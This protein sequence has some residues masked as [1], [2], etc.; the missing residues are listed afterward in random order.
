MLDLLDQVEDVIS[1]EEPVRKDPKAFLS[2]TQGR[3][4]DERSIKCDS[5]VT[6]LAT[7]STEN[8]NREPP[9][10]YFLVLEVCFSIIHYN[11]ITL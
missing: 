11:K 10:I 4:D 8:V 2:K 1:V 7:G 5:T 6:A 3:I 9:N